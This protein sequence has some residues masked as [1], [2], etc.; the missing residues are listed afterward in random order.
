MTEGD[1]ESLN[2]ESV[3]KDLFLY[4]EHVNIECVAL[5][6]KKTQNEVLTVRMLW[7]NW[8]RY[9]GKAVGGMLNIRY[10]FEMHCRG[11]QTFSEKRQ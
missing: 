1:S 7:Q 3:S 5:K 4:S 8:D 6:G 11:Q 9:A 10:E 2:L